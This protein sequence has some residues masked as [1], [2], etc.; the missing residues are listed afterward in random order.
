MF[1]N[2]T[3]FRK[4]LS[5]VIAILEKKDRYDLAAILKNGSVSPEYLS[6][7]NWNG[8]ID[9]YCIDIELDINT[10]AQIENKLT[11]CEHEIEEIFQILIRGQEWEHLNG[12]II[13]PTLKYVLDWSSVSDLSNKDDLIKSIE[14][15]KALMIS[16]STGGPDIKSQNQSYKQEY[17][18]IANILKKLKLENPNPF[19]DLWKWYDK[20]KNGDLPR[21]ADRR[22]FIGELYDELLDI[23]SSAEDEGVVDQ[24]YEMTGWIKVDR[25]ISEMRKRIKEAKQE[26]QFQSIGLLGREALI[27]LAQEVYNDS[28]HKPI[29]GVDPSDTDAKRKLEAYISTE[30]IGGPNEELRNYAKSTIK[31]ANYLTHHRT[32]DYNDAS[33]CL[34]SVTSLVNMIK[35]I[36]HNAVI[37]F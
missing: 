33:L 5:T 2:K 36:S 34:I 1:E 31:L 4:S 28:I 20:W 7:D 8:G 30:L 13:R 24:P 19:N 23:L 18:R 6:H 25:T 21:Y 15:L 10:Y 12:V 14:A 29:D 27:S 26:E 16:V 3:E 22:S 32:A 11:V 17:N 37:R 9:Y 35:V